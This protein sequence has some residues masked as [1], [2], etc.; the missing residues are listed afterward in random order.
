[1]SFI[2]T[3]FWAKRYDFQKG[4]IQE[5]S[6]F[7]P[8]QFIVGGVSISDKRSGFRGGRKEYHEAAAPAGGHRGAAD[9][10]MAQ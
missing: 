7:V 3:S 8:Q 10:S 5:L 9:Q 2:S 6:A 1:M 4:G